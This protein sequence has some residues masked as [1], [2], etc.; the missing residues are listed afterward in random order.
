V[1]PPLLL[2]VHE[3]LSAADIPHA[4][5]GAAALAVHGVSRSTFDQDLLVTGMRVLD[6]HIWASLSASARVD[7]RHGDDDDPLAG[8]VRF[9]ADDERDVD[10]IV[11]RDEWQ[12]EIIQEAL[13]HD[14]RAGPIPVASPAGLVLLKLYAGGPQ[15]HWDIE[16]LRAIGGPALDAAVA[17]RVVRLP[18]TVRDAWRRLASGQ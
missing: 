17:S 8:V 11:G 4:L 1:T 18:A 10:V 13:I 15:D 6:P 16:Q 7:I 3:A 2:R 12:R 5:I 14:L 9:R